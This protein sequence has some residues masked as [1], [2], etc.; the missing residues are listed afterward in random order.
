MPL[1][2]GNIW[3]GVRLCP[4]LKILA[5]VFTHIAFLGYSLKLFTR[6][7]KRDVCPNRETKGLMS[8]MKPL[9]QSEGFSL[10]AEL[11]AAW[12]WFRLWVNMD[13]EN[14]NTLKSLQ[15]LRLRGRVGVALAPPHAKVESAASWASDEAPSH[16]HS[17]QH[18]TGVTHI[19]LPE[20]LSQN[21]KGVLG[22]FFFFLFYIYIFLFWR[23][24]TSLCDVF[25]ATH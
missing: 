22:I 3:S 12:G 13:S 18:H 23:I 8:Q 1:D 21:S 7:T 4:S 2:V 16:S 9:S 5:E 6:H 10:P 17:Q 11:I 15:R 24:C 19:F 20:L 25:F 14:K